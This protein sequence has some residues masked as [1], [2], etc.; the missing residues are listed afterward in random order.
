MYLDVYILV[1]YNFT[2]HCHQV[3]T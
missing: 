3:D 1:V 2:D